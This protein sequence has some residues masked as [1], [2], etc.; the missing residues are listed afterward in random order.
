MSSRRSPDV[1]DCATIWASSQ[2]PTVPTV[3]RTVLPSGSSS[4]HRWLNS[5][6]CASRTV[7]CEGEPPAA[8]TFNSPDPVVGA[9]TITSPAPQLPPNPIGAS[10]I[11][12]TG[13]PPTATLLSFPPEK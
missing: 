7:A 4:G 2:L 11:V 13:P 3:K 12:V 6:F 1:N 5:P 8:D 10:Q 9:N